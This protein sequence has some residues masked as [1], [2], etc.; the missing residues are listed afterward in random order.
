[1]GV[2]TKQGDGDM[3]FHVTNLRV[4]MSSVKAVLLYGAQTW[5]LTKELKQKLH[6]FVNK[7]CK[8]TMWMLWPRRTRNQELWK[9]ALQKPIEEEITG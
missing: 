1:M 6:V 3:V 5:R 4:S 8:N 9:Q 7:C 2:G